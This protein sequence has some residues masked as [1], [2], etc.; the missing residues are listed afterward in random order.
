[1]AIEKGTI[2]VVWVTDNTTRIYSKMFDDI[3]SARRF[4]KKKDDY[5]IFKLLWNK[6]FKTFAWTILPYGNYKLYQSS[7]KF[8]KKYKGK[9]SIIKNLFQI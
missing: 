5:L 9:R 4:A 2:K 3:D 7:L 1:M 8:Y 6:N